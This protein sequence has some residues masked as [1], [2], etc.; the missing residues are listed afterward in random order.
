MYNY[1]VI[2]IMSV[3][4]EISTKDLKKKNIRQKKLNMDFKKM[5]RKCISCSKHYKRNF[6]WKVRIV[7]EI[8][9]KQG[10]FDTLYLENYG[11]L[12]VY[13]AKYTYFT[14]FYHV[15]NFL[16]LKVNF[17]YQKSEKRLTSEMYGARWWERRQK[18]VN[19]EKTDQRL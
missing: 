4:G 8:L 5:I 19:Q 13:L 16:I 17:P 10:N 15:Q 18:E 7:S 12:D 6:S 14:V 2:I 11:F 9:K 3:P 1:R